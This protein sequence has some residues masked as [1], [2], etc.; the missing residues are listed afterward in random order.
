MLSRSRI[1]PQKGFALGIIDTKIRAAWKTAQKINPAVPGSKIAVPA[2][3][4][5]APHKAERNGDNPGNCSPRHTL[6]LWKVNI[7]APK[8][9]NAP[10]KANIERAAKEMRIEKASFIQPITAGPKA[11]ITQPPQPRI[12]VAAAL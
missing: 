5:P 7:L 4:R 10:N 1:F 9:S 6:S 3:R 11:P 12:P 8:R 2:F